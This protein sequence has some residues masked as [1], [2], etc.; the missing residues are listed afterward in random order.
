MMIDCRTDEW[1]A[2]GYRS[3]HSHDEES[4]RGKRD[5]E[6]SDLRFPKFDLD[7]LAFDL[8]SWV[9]LIVRSTI[10]CDSFLLMPNLTLLSASPFSNLRIP[11]WESAPRRS[12]SQESME[13]DMVPR[14]V[15]SFER[16]KSR[17]I[18]PTNALSV[19][20]TPSSALVLA[21]GSAKLATRLL[22]EARTPSRPLRP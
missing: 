2:V 18:P 9:F 20:R 3:T 5:N 8:C 15:S 21:S 17:S 10:S 4:R 1:T 12:E 14:C 11:K 16:L 19:E 7:L 22:L 13:P 6:G